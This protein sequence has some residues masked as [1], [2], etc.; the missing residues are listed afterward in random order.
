MASSS[1][2]RNSYY[3]S[4]SHEPSRRQQSRRQ[5]R[6]RSSHGTVSTTLSSS[7]GRESYATHVTE[8]PAYSKKIVV[9]GDGGCGKTC[10]LISYSQGYFPEKYVPTVFENYITY[11]THS[12]TGKTVEL[13]LWDTAGQEEYDRLR[14]LSYPETDLIFVCFAIDCPNSLDNVLD[15]WY[16]EVLHFCPYTPLILVGLKSDLRYKQTCIE[17]LKTQGLTP[18]TTEQGLAVADKMDAQ[19]MECSSKEMLGVDEIFERAILTV[20]ANDRAN[21]EAMVGNSGGDGRSAIPGLK[22]PKRKKR[23]CQ[24]L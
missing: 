15:K 10:L 5:Q 6:T 8:A 13:A 4:S 3:T 11:P 9:V 23:R 18:V 20:V 2:H 19:Y 1:Q 14:P 7:S 24:I 16:P 22:L 12:P 21:Q 17:M